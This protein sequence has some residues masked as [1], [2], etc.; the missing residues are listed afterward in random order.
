MKLLEKKKNTQT[1]RMMEYIVPVPGNL[2][3]ES[4][5]PLMEPHQLITKIFVA[6]KMAETHL[7]V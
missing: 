7:T 1:L 3:E 2:S 6:R 4:R 5:Q